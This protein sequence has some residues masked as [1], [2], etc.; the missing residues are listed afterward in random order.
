MWPTFQ[1]TTDGKQT[2]GLHYVNNE[3]TLKTNEYTN[4][5]QVI[6]ISVACWLTSLSAALP[7]CF[8][9][10]YLRV[11]GIFGFVMI[12]LSSFIAICIINIKVHTF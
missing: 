2:D 10:S 1:L 8:E 9:V 4:N 6:K 12:G 7:F 3:P 11:I 5:K